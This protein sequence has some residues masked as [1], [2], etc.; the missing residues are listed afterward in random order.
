MKIVFLFL[1]VLAAA[2]TA[3]GCSSSESSLCDAKCDCEGCSER[4]YNNCLDGYDRDARDAEYRG[5]EGYY[6]DLLACREDT[7][8]CRGSDFDTSCNVERDRFKNCI[9]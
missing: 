4:D 5:C 9:D 3:P 1:F 8:R 7:W 2:V 6:D